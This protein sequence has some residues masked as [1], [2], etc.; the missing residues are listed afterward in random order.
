MLEKYLF[1]FVDKPMLDITNYSASMDYLSNDCVTIKYL[2]NVI[3]T[4]LDE[5]QITFIPKDENKSNI[6]IE[7]HPVIYLGIWYNVWGHLLTDVLSRFWYVGSMEYFEKK[8]N[9]YD[10]LY[11]A[12]DDSFPIQFYDLLEIIGVKRQRLRKIN[13]VAY[14]SSVYIPDDSLILKTDDKI[15]GKDVDLK[16]GLFFYT[17]EYE[18]LINKIKLNVEPIKTDKIF[19]TVNRTSKFIGILNIER[20][21][22]KSGFN[23]LNPTKLSFK[24]QMSYISG[25]DTFCTFEGSISFNALF[26]KENSELVLIR[27]LP[28]IDPYQFAIN[29][30]S[31]SKVIYIDSHLS[32]CCDKNFPYL[33]PFML[34]LSENLINYLN[35]SSH[36][37]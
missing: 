7:T 26:L 18:K 25:C 19:F 37:K 15:I 28:Y 13:K 31:N 29:Q 20:V 2:E 22:R 12:E 6:L 8:L 21:M 34:Y 3:L 30:I 35:I 27:K 11:Y 36:K 33:G 4:P 5:T 32:F 24:E 17:P 14:C 16:N 9:E 1:D 10:I 23:I